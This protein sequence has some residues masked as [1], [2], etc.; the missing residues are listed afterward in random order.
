MV[1]KEWVDLVA[2][3]AVTAWEMSLFRCAGDIIFDNREPRRDVLCDVKLKSFSETSNILQY[4][5]PLTPKQ[6]YFFAKIHTLG[7][8]VHGTLEHP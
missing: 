2:Y 4:L 5:K 7:I 3:T 6:P 1:C 8:R